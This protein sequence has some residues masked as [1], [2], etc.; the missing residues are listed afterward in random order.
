MHIKEHIDTFS[1][2]EGQQEEQV[3][4]INEIEKIDNEILK[5]D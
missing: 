5:V 1:I 3:L 4:N 2:Q